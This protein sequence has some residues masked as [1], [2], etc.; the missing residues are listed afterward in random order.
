MAQLKTYKGYPLWLY[1]PNTA[2]AVIFTMLFAAGT[3]AVVWRTIKARAWY[4]TVLIIGG[5]FQVVGYAARIAARDQTDQL[6]PYIIQSTLIL[7]APALFAASVYMVLGRVITSVH[8]ETY[9]PIRP[10]TLTALFVT[11]DVLSFAVQASGA[12]VMVQDG[13]QDMGEKIILAGLFIQ[14]IIFGLFIVTSYI[15]HTR[16]NKNR[17]DTSRTYGT[18]WR[19]ILFMLYAVSGLIMIRSIFRVIEYAMGNDGYLLSHEWTLYIFDALLMFVV[20][21]LFAWYFPGSFKTKA[22][23]MEMSPQEDARSSM[24]PF[25]SANDTR[26]VFQQ[27][28]LHYSK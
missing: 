5:L 10:K 16:I 15:F 24:T 20:V 14:I 27:H 4:C 13:Q 21:A 3:A 6:V 12:G 9:S 1:L 22:A 28:D 18:H 19:T 2:A 7:V 25:G 17:P 11:G 8:G 26:E 23:D